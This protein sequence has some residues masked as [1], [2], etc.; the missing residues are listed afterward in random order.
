VKILQVISS[1]PPAY[2]YGGALKV[3]YGISK[4]LVKNNHDVTVY[5]TDVYDSNTRLHY[6]TNPEIMD[7][8]K[9]Y[10]FRNIS[11]FLSRKNLTCTPSMFL[12]LKNNIQEFDI[13]HLHEYRSFQAVFVHYYAKKYQIPYIVQAHGSVLPAFEKQG[14]KKLFDIF[15]GNQVLRDA[16]KLI[17][18]SNI[19][20]EQ[21]LNMGIP[22]SKIKIIPNGID[23]SEYTTLP[24]RGN[25]RKKFG[26][27]S[28]VKI[29]LFLGRLHKS[30][31]IDFLIDCF[32]GL[33][34]P[35]KN[36]KLVIAGPDDGYLDILT[37][38][39]KKLKI[40]NNV[41]ITGSR[42]NTEKI[43]AFVD[44]DVL[45]YPGKIEIFWLVPFEALM[46]GTP[47]IVTDDCGCGEVIKEAK[48]GYLVT[49]GDIEDLRKKM[50]QI[51]NDNIHANLFI[52]NGQQY[53]QDNLSW[54]CIVGCVER[55]YL[56][57]ISQSNGVNYE[58]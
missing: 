24:V 12:F 58:S 13:I 56:E 29:I 30:K 3:A 37:Y 7:G 27:P 33:L 43:E 51:L 40:E 34:D 46:C 17:A 39:I 23:V 36:I 45:V 11:N 10:R 19:E 57:S 14:I 53:I 38:Q 44:A 9:V 25:F 49:Y 15:W 32:S 55:I 18:V 20:K 31:G 54:S 5:T 52:R 8:I 48:C 42:Y 50:S 35:C 2:A 6:N 41:L 16:S 28:D 22:E 4:E 26:I 1:F 47:V 21:Y